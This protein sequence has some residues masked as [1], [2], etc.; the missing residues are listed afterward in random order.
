[1][2]YSAA[3]SKPDLIIGP[4]SA[5]LCY[6]S[7]QRKHR[8]HVQLWADST[9]IP[10]LLGALHWEKPSKNSAYQYH[11]FNTAFLIKP[12]KEELVPYRKIKLVP[13]S[14]AIPFEGLFPI[15][16]RVNLG[17]A[18]FQR[19]K[20]ATVYTINDSIHIAPFICYES[21]YPDFVQKRL[22]RGANCIVH[23]TNDG[24]F[25]KSTGPYQ[26]AIM[27]RMRAIEN[28]VAMARCAITGVSMFVDPFGRVLKSTRLGRRTIVVEKLPLQRAKTFYARFGDWLVVA[29]A[30]MISGAFFSILVQIAAKSGRLKNINQS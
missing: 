5:L 18:D 24:W 27:A 21:I 25:G 22:R 26:H 2:V 7:R 13:F 15:L 16:S 23:I 19:G 6:L 8:R 3:K 11:V 29:C 4:E 28:G 14:E 12:D 10:I 17:E 1:M 30:I 9:G 20:E